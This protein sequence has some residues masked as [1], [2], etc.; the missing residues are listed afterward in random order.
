MDN[1]DNL[2]SA[3]ISNLIDEKEKTLSVAINNYY[4]IEQEKLIL[5]K[6][7]LE[8]Q[9]RKKDLE[10]NLSKAGHILKQLNIE[11]KL[12]RS[13]FWSVKNGGL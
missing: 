5:Q 6:D 3:Q 10:I 1:L 11:L 2:S 13:K 9:T 4:T 12:L 8:H 7:I